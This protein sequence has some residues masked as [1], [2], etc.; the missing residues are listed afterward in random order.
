MTFKMLVAFILYVVQ[1]F[2]P[3]MEF[4]TNL[5]ELSESLGALKRVMTVFNLPEEILNDGND[6]FVIKK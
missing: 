6:D 3:S 1:L 2:N 4:I 5:S